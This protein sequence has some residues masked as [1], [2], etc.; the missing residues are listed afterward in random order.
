LII[1]RI[2]SIFEREREVKYLK[3]NVMSEDQGVY[4]K[5]QWFIKSNTGK[6]EDSYDLDPKKVQI[7]LSFSLPSDIFIYCSI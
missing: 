5:K 6:I 2:I 1:I 4:L 7:F 3:R